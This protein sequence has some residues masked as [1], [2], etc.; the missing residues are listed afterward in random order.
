MDIIGCI[1]KWVEFRVVLKGFEFV[2]GVIFV[3]FVGCDV[4]ICFVVWILMGEL[5]YC[6]FIGICDVINGFFQFVV[7]GLDFYDL[8]VL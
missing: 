6:G 8:Q 1:Y 3:C 5:I 2:G 4:D 7:V